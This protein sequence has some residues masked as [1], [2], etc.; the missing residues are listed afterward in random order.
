[1]RPHP[2]PPGVP[3]RRA[4]Q[5]PVALAF[6]FAVTLRSPYAA[7]LFRPTLPG[8]PAFV[9]HC[10]RGLGPL[11]PFCV[12]NCSTT[13]PRLWMNRA[14]TTTCGPDLNCVSG[15]LLVRRVL[16]SIRRRGAAY[17]AAR[18]AVPRGHLPR[19]MWHGVWPTGPAL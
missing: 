6:F 18:A 5:L 13:V 16:A 9:A 4:V 7:S 17:H 11:R 1:V 19:P 14:S 2:P 12:V 10:V 15:S 3:G 8:G